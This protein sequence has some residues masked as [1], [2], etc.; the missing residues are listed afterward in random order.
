MAVN[1]LTVTLWLS[2]MSAHELEALAYLVENFGAP[3]CV[4]D[5]DEFVKKIDERIALTIRKD[6]REALTD[7]VAGF[8]ADRKKEM[9]Q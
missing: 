3:N 1:E 7:E 2:F 8:F 4:P 5:V 9:E 6:K